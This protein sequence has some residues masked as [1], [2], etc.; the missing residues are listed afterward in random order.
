VEEEEEEE[1]GEERHFEVPRQRKEIELDRMK[2]EQRDAWV[3][4]VLEEKEAF[5]TLISDPRYQFEIEHPGYP[6]R[7]TLS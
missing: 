4:K 7:P 6:A 5:N 2:R 1:G 3:A